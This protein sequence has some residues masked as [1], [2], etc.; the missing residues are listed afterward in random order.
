[1]IR[2]G[3][4]ASA[5][6]RPH[7][8]AGPQDARTPMAPTDAAGGHRHPAPGPLAGRERA[9]PARDPHPHLPGPPHPPPARLGSPAAPPPLRPRRYLSRLESIDSNARK[10]LAR[11]GMAPYWGTFVPA[12]I[13]PRWKE[14]NQERY[15]TPY[16]AIRDEIYA[17]YRAIVEEVLAEYRAISRD[18]Y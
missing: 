6:G 1:P 8:R 4:T 16:F 7:G 3:T 18:N 9:Q 5:P 15:E 12:D 17:N 11:C 10:W 14:V 2:T 13:Y